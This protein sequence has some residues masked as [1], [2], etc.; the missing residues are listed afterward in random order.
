MKTNVSLFVI[1]FSFF[2]SLN[3]RAT[4][5]TPNSVPF[6]AYVLNP[7]LSWR[8]VPDSPIF[9]YVCSRYDSQVRVPEAASLMA[10]LKQTFEAYDQKIKTLEERIQA[11]ESKLQNTPN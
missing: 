2:I 4:E 1:V 5:L 3:S 7:C 6:Q 11:L 10:S 9:G 8:F